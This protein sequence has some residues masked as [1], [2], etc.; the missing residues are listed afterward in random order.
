MVVQPA[1]QGCASATARV[2]ERLQ[3]NPPSELRLHL[4]QPAQTIPRDALVFLRAEPTP[5]GVYVGWPWYGGLFCVS[6]GAA[7]L[8]DDSGEERR[9]TF[10]SL[11][12]VREE[13]KIIKDLPLIPPELQKIPPE[14]E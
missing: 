12:D 13:I 9:W 2:I 4:L 6:R 14:E 1:E 7:L 11:R 8:Y 10:R 5:D 3:G